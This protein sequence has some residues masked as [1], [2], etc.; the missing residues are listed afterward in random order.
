VIWQ[1][2]NN[3]WY[4]PTWKCCANEGKAEFI[5]AMPSAAN[6][7]EKKYECRNDSAGIITKPALDRAEPNGNYTNQIASGKQNS[8]RTKK[9][10][11]TV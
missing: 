10:I 11:V 3:W 5:R 4:N 8:Q 2:S 1:V 6:I 9:Q 7:L